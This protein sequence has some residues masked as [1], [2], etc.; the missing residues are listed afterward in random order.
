MRES[1]GVTGAAP[2]MNEMLTHL[3]ARFGTTW[4]S[5]P[6]G[7]REAFIHP[8][9]GHAVPQDFPGGVTEKCVRMPEASTAADFDNAGRVALPPEYSA[10]ASS[11]HCRLSGLVSVPA[12]DRPLQILQP[13]PG[14]VY[15][16][17][18][19]LPG[20][21]QQIMLEA[22]RPVEW[23]GIGLSKLAASKAA[24]LPLRSGIHT[25]SARDPATGQSASTWIEVKQL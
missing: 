23:S 4:N 5:P 2:A 12:G 18:P 1:T 8:L 6:P 14:T 24:K 10:W 3:H 20:D 22:A 19:D 15:F 16:L 11:P 13:A 9:I 7:I 25:I 17:D 21:R